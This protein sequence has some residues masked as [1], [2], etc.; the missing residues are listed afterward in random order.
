MVAVLP[1][2][3]GEAGKDSAN[4][5]CPSS[6]GMITGPF[7]RGCS[8]ISIS[9]DLNGYCETPRNSFLELNSFEN[10]TITIPNGLLCRALFHEIKRQCCHSKKVKHCLL[11]MPKESH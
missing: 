7:Y 6:A 9:S 11:T 8:V 10:G 5:E 1:A 2:T 4:E 3:A